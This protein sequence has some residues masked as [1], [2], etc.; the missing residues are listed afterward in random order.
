MQIEG[1]FPLISPKKAFFQTFTGKSPV[2]A[3]FV[4]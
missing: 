4:A 3:M 1:E 2:I